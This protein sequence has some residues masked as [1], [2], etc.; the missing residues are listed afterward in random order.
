MA[1][2]GSSHKHAI[3]LGALDS[4]DKDGDDW[5][6]EDEHGQDY[7]DDE[8]EEDEEDDGWEEE[9]EER[10]KTRGR[11]GASIMADQSN[12][13]TGT[14]MVAR[15]AT[16]PL[17]NYSSASTAATVAVTRR[18]AMTPG[19][20]GDR[21]SS[22]RTSASGVARVSVASVSGVA[23]GMGVGM[24][25]LGMGTSGFG[26]GTGGVDES[27][28]ASALGLVAP[29][30]SLAAATLQD[31][32]AWVHVLDGLIP[33][34]AGGA[35]ERM[36]KDRE[37]AE[38]EKER[39]EEESRRM[40]NEM[41]RVEKEWKERES[42]VQSHQQSKVLTQH[43]G[44]SMTQVAISAPSHP[45]A[46][47]VA[48]S[49]KSIEAA[50][51]A[52]RG[53]VE[54]LRAV[55]EAGV[56]EAR[57]NYAETQAGLERSRDAAERAMQAQIGVAETV[58]QVGRGLEAV[59]AALVMTGQR[60]A[61]QPA[62]SLQ[63]VEDAVREA[64]HQLDRRM[65]QVRTM[66]GEVAEAVAGISE[67]GSAAAGSERVLAEVKQLR[68]EVLLRVDE[69]SDRMER[70]VAHAIA[71]AERAGEVTDSTIRLGSAIAKLES[72]VGGKLA[73][74]Q[75][76]IAETGKIHAASHDEE[77]AVLAAVVERKA[78]TTQRAIDSLR[79]D[80]EAGFRAAKLATSAHGAPPAASRHGES[81]KEQSMAT[82]FSENS[83]VEI[84]DD[85]SSL[86]REVRALV[87]VKDQV[88]AVRKDV[89][90]GLREMQGDLVATRQDVSRL[91][92]V[93]GTVTVESARNLDQITA[94]VR[95]IMEKSAT[96]ISERHREEVQTMKREVKDALRLTAMEVSSSVV[97][98]T[99]PMK[100]AASD[101]R[102]CSREVVERVEAIDDKLSRLGAQLQTSA[103]A[104][105]FEDIS[106]T[107]SGFGDSLK[108][109]TD[110][111]ELMQAKLDNIIEVSGFLHE[112]QCRLL[113][114]ASSPKK[115]CKGLPE[116]E[117][118]II[119]AI[120][121][122]RE[123]IT[124][125]VVAEMRMELAKLGSGNSTLSS[126]VKGGQTLLRVATTP[127]L[128]KMSIAERETLRE[129]VED[130][131][132]TTML[133]HHKSIGV[134]ERAAL[135]LVN[136]RLGKMI[137]LWEEAASKGKDD[138]CPTL[139]HVALS[140]PLGDLPPSPTRGFS[141]RFA[142]EVKHQLSDIDHRLVRLTKEDQLNHDI[143]A[144]WLKQI[145]DNLRGLRKEVN[146]LGA[147][148]RARDL[149]SPSADMLVATAGGEQIAV[150]W[151]SVTGKIEG[152]LEELKKALERGLSRAG[153]TDWR[154]ADSKAKSD[155]RV[156]ATSASASDVSR[157]LRE[158]QHSVAA[159]GKDWN[160]E[161]QILKQTIQEA[162]ATEMT[163]LR[164]N[165]DFSVTQRLQHLEGTVGVTQNV[166]EE[167]QG[168][169]KK[170]GQ[171]PSPQFQLLENAM[172]NLKE[173]MKQLGDKVS[174]ARQPKVDS[175]VT[176][177]HSEPLY[178][179][180]RDNIVAIRN[181][182][183]QTTLTAVSAMS[184]MMT[185]IKDEI[186]TEFRSTPAVDTSAKEKVD[187]IHR[188][189]TRL[190]FASGEHHRSVEGIV[191]GAQ[192][193]MKGDFQE[194]ERR[195]EYLLEIMKKEL[196][197]QL[198]A[199]THNR[200]TKLDDEISEIKR[201]LLSRQYEN[202][203]N[204]SMNATPESLDSPHTLYSE[205]TEEKLSIDLSAKHIEA[206]NLEET[207]S[208]LEGRRSILLEEVDTLLGSRH[209]LEDQVS[210][211]EAR[212]VQLNNEIRSAKRIQAEKR[213][214]VD[215]EA[216][217]EVRS[218]VEEAIKLESDVKDRT[219]VLV[220]D[221]ARLQDQKRKLAAE[222]DRLRKEKEEIDG[223]AFL[224]GW[225]RTYA[226]M[227]RTAS[228][229]SLGSAVE[230][231]A[232]RSSQDEKDSPLGLSSN[233]ALRS[234]G[235]FTPNV[236]SPGSPV[237]RPESPIDNAESLPGAFG[238]SA[239][240]RPPKKSSTGSPLRK[241]SLT[242]RKKAGEMISVGASSVHQEES[243]ET[244]ATEKAPG[245]GFFGLWKA[246]AMK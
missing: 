233:S 86:K 171:D 52:V 199:V 109:R 155:N 194:H 55:C 8:D 32:D 197:N 138:L 81:K 48:Q 172:N 132:A 136:D 160:Q 126:P 59:R 179:D 16:M 103:L 26:T 224:P 137:Q 236:A 214:S 174:V 12:A 124:S 164:D 13:T 185:A 39:A 176:L 241:I 131:V 147:I 29:G 149:R 144:G 99:K 107:L 73:Q 87:D 113:K 118:Q 77:R 230:K 120:E 58:A 54:D 182:P 211:L 14:A 1:N 219:R 60:Q 150:Q 36:V 222:V 207:I 82:F 45:S 44:S 116:E 88:A 61:S 225:T 23:I 217:R 57:S 122:S 69:A 246:P 173:E 100:D 70:T 146:E 237:G 229:A 162:V 34:A 115:V 106:T 187:Q 93:V 159:L 40:R 127:N 139:E 231:D 175:A 221:M 129:I 130:A 239:G 80:I 102:K 167:P 141:D 220:A 6:G 158:L 198:D 215:F 161:I 28:S 111:D 7:D 208:T 195:M 51:G 166:R 234:E 62:L 157:A 18:G 112:S 213:R 190:S 156:E 104:A 152:Q 203:K 196:Q 235:Y 11:G 50:T 75:S 191:K 17:A 242:L 243:L 3:S 71:T 105:K 22:G 31:R 68:E 76:T 238:G 24:A 206:Q 41:E 47:V 154:F 92:D 178:S 177:L 201:L 212:L 19:S 5:L 205:G 148:E 189:I 202:S 27:A 97:E 53:A 142:G 21:Q 56:E 65:F 125:K 38:R 25:G 64:Q 193:E 232:K 184:T 223:G 117:E 216:Q 101:A 66:V 46:S 90:S 63:P 10:E 180:I 186:L 84:K 165:A 9:E 181:F 95:G 83:V 134:G 192:D 85:I 226:A 188:T 2:G 43:Q 209:L 123:D 108:A 244:H 30:W 110:S 151:G 183:E 228:V 35:V 96:G 89:G 133:A 163:K 72:E 143:L 33:R 15:G 145:V 74:I 140:P 42:R 79:G 168:S 204:P 240:E 67:Q 121:R 98:A 135:A 91:L 200:S 37:R 210:T 119:K 170:D 114:V 94:D 78:E 169:V 128:H 4:L 227:A 245:G 218:L 49:V 153:A 20:E